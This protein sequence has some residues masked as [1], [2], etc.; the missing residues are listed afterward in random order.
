[1]T[2]KQKLK[3]CKDILQRNEV[4]KRLNT[5]DE[6]FMIEIFS[7]HHDIANS[8]KE[9]MTIGIIKSK[10]F[11]NKEFAIR[12]NDG[13]IRKEISYVKAV[14]GNVSLESKIRQAAR[15][16]ITDLIMNFK[17]SKL[18]DNYGICEI[19][20]KKLHSDNLAIDHYDLTFQQLLRYFIYS[21]GIDKIE[22]NMNGSNFNDNYKS[23]FIE[24]HNNHSKLRIIDSELNSILG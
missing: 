21:V 6:K 1:M 17:L 2:K 12:F 14:N 4:N 20:N 5:D 23:L 22:K 15:R 13:T 7:N 10:R 9:I 11:N 18:N 8:N 19:T 16:A 3:L 24:F